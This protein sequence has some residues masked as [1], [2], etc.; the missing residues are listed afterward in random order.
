MSKIM[1]DCEVQA[2]TILKHDIES[3]CFQR[4]TA[5][6]SEQAALAWCSFDLLPNA[7]FVKNT[8]GKYVYCN[9]AQAKKY[10]LS[11]EEF[12]TF[13][14]EQA[15]WAAFSQVHAEGDQAALSNGYFEGIVPALYQG[16]LRMEYVRKV[17]QKD[18]A[19]NAIGV[20]GFSCWLDQLNSA[21]INAQAFKLVALTKKHGRELFHG[22]TERESHVLYWLIRGESIRQIAERLQLSPATVRTYLDNLKQRW[23]KPTAAALIEKALADGFAFFRPENLP[24]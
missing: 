1:S 23:R 12:L 3:D 17:A 6:D 20:I 13:A 14:N 15:P 21:A 19:G 18:A 11:P 16:R 2:M 22:M 24:E 8:E 4:L 9:P 10:D 7:V 5:S